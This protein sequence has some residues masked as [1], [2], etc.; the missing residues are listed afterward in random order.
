M[1]LSLISAP[2]ETRTRILRLVKV[3]L[4]PLSYRGVGENLMEFMVE[5]STESEASAKPDYVEYYLGTA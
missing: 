3:V 5:S 2:G 1:R 4:Y